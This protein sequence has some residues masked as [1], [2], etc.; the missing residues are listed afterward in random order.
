MKPIYN[1][2]SVT[3]LLICI[4]TLCVVSC[5]KDELLNAKPS[6]SLAIPQTL[7][8]FQAILDNQTNMNT[9]P[10]L[11]DAS[12]DNYNM[13]YA[14]FQARSIQ[15]QAVYIWASDIWQGLINIEDWNIS[16]STV[17]YA[18]LVLEGL[19]KYSASNTTQL[20]YDNIKG[21]ALFFRANAFLNSASLFAPQFDSSIASQPI[22]IPLKLNSN[23][24]SQS[25]RSTLGET[26]SKIL[27]DLTLA[28]SL[29]PSSVNINNKN[30][31]SRPAAYALLA[32]TYLNM[33]NYSKA[34]LYAD[35][36]LQLY[37][38]LN[39][40]NNVKLSASNYAPYNYTNNNEVLFNAYQSV[41]NTSPSGIVINSITGLSNQLNVDS[42]LVRSYNANDLRKQIYYYVF[43]NN[44]AVNLNGSYSGKF[45]PFSGMAVNE[46]Y[47]IRAECYARAGNSS[48]AMTDLNTLLLKRW[49]TSTFTLSTALNSNDALSQILI[50]R[51]K[52]L[53]F[54]N[55]R[56]TDLR[57]L[58]KD[59]V[60]I[61]LVRIVN[62]QTFTLA[63]NDPK[64]TLPI[65][66]DV[67][68]FSGMTQNPR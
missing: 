34:G 54:S 36:S 47:L 16:Y 37:N 1:S 68:Q 48:A 33:R 57:R 13:T 64:Y 17:L 59:G 46:M 42:S 9:T 23:I 43:S 25:N 8:D 21:Q 10:A 35:S 29:L 11:G 24:N 20:T 61:N 45:N 28:A 56:W 50:E 38:T 3:L 58:N 55:V 18:N 49:K 27:L 2:L 39:D 62:G 12:S 44:G 19:D 4:I 66:P 14:F 51:R 5:N 67:I 32:R 26:Y 63:A 60:N 15:T 40:L 6:T 22:G 41:S 31:P 30:R 52:E 65:P 53:P 7:E